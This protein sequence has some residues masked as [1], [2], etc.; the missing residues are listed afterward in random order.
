MAV[1]YGQ[2]SGAAH[3]SI[4]MVGTRVIYDE[5]ARE[6][7]LK[8][9]NRGD[10][11][12]VVQ[13]WLDNGD[14]QSSPETADSP[15]AVVPSIAKV[16]PNEG[17]SLRMVFTGDVSALPSDRESVFYL[18]V[19]EIPSIRAEQTG[20][21]RL[22]LL[23]K[24]RLKVFYRP[25]GLP[26][27]SGSLPDRLAAARIENDR[28]Q[29]ELLVRNPTPYHASFR[30]ATVNARGQSFAVE[31][32]GMIPPFSAQRWLVEAGDLGASPEL[33]ITLVDDHGGNRV[34]ALPLSRRAQE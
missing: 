30:N 3:A 7:T 4:V 23:T 25:E 6:V 13:A 10:G 9:S 34:R 16:L 24:H 19:L 11:P 5:N 29:T 31:G 21:N 33:S 2:L 15:F 22:V 18:N 20:Q 12:V 28:G 14:Q 8:L 27:A 1:L 26:E 32:V 17:Q